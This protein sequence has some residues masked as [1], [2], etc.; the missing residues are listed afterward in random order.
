M[1]HA[2]S[3]AERSPVFSFDAKKNE[4]TRAFEASNEAKRDI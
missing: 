2:A 3:A 1:R 4:R